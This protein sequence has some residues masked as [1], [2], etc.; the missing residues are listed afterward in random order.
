MHLARSSA[1]VGHVDVSTVL[2]IL[3][4]SRML[5]HWTSSPL[6]LLLAM[7]LMSVPNLGQKQ[8]R[9]MSFPN[10]LDDMYKKVH[11]HSSHR[12]HSYTIN[13][14]PRIYPSITK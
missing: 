11:S 12:T 3:V 14:I 9:L 7:S 13:A 4:V 10:L 6:L 5:G 2:V 1:A 8:G